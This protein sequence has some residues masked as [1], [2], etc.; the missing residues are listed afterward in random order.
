MMFFGGVQPGWEW[1]RNNCKIKEDVVM[2]ANDFMEWF[3]P[4]DYDESLMLIYSDP[5]TDDDGNECPEELISKN[6]ED[7]DI[8]KELCRLVHTGCCER[9]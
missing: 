3:K 8:Y 7:F 5:Y 6:D 9:I 1:I 4:N 2:E